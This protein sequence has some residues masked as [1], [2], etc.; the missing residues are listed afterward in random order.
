GAAVTGSGAAARAAATRSGAALRAEVSGS[1]AAARAAV[2]GSGGAAGLGAAFGSTAGAVEAASF[3]EF[4][5]AL[6]DA[7][8]AELAPAAVA[9]GVGS[10]D[11]VLVVGELVCVGGTRGAAARATCAM[12]LT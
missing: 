2:T 8:G 3:T 7:F 4:V 10:A 11:G 9:C 6:C 1:G 12:V 5:E